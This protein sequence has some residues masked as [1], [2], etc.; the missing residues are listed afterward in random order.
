[1][2]FHF[3]NKI[4]SVIRENGLILPGESVLIAVSGGPDSMCLAFLLYKLQYRISVAHVNF[5]LRGPESEADETLVK[6]WCLHTG[7][8]FHA[9]SFDTESEALGL[10][11]GIQET[12]RQLRYDW[13]EQLAI[14][15]HYDKIAV[16]HHLDDQAETV[17]FNLIRGSG[18][19]GAKGISMQQGKIIRPMISIPKIEILNYINEHQI[20]FREDRSNQGSDYSRNKIRNEIFPLLNSINPKA[21]TN[22]AL[23]GLRIQAILPGYL[24]WKKAQIEKYL[25]REEQGIIIKSPE[26][27]DQPLWY[28]LLEEFGFNEDQVNQLYRSI[29]DKAVGKLF[30]APQYKLYYA[31]THIEIRQTS[32]AHQQVDLEIEQLPFYTKIGENEIRLEWW[33]PDQPHAVSWQVD[34]RNHSF[35]LH[36]RTWL[37]GDRF[38]PLGM[39]SGS[40]KIQD[41]LTDLKISGFYKKQALVLVTEG[42][43]IWVWPQGRISELVKPGKEK[44]TIMT[45]SMVDSSRG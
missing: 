4:N 45:I 7:V 23:F 37:P 42:E 32:D 35:P 27:I 34:L 16:A 26:N 24:A 21:S 8:P 3:E 22:M 29:Q 17:L 20:P 38:T 44:S 33:H 10:K 13:F 25:I 43:I 30:L 31:G 11:K 39:Q 40:K 6:E 9:A 1:M 12:A 19:A 2:A 5:N 36:L 18:L 28:V 15:F 14:E 41:Y